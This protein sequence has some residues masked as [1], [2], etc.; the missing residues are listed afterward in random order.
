MER[1]PDLW[2]MFATP[3]WWTVAEEVFIFPGHGHVHARSVVES[4]KHQGHDKKYIHLSVMM[5]KGK[6]RWNGV[7]VLMD[8][9]LR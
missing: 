6:W 8:D 5:T 1:E 9:L 7:A 4:T 3:C 2:P